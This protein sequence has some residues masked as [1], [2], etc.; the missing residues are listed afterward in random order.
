M[1]GQKVLHLADIIELSEIAEDAV[2]AACRGDSNL[3]EDGNL[4]GDGR[5]TREAGERELKSLRNGGEALFTIRDGKWMGRL[6]RDHI[7]EETIADMRDRYFCQQSGK[8][9]NIMKSIA[10]WEGKEMGEDI[11]DD[12]LLSLFVVA[13]YRK[14]QQM[15]EIAEWNRQNHIP[16]AVPG[17]EDVWYVDLGDDIEIGTLEYVASEYCRDGLVYLYE[18]GPRSGEDPV[19]HAHSFEEVLRAALDAPETFSIEG[20]EDCYSGQ[21]RH[22]LQS[23]LARLRTG[24]KGGRPQVV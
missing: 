18:D 10:A 24:K 7:M 6:I 1:A 9:C 17:E 11:T 3:D 12:A 8:I 16:A 20:H 4:V 15:D 13:W 2:G 22:F 21:E 19:P 14:L 5:W 23:F